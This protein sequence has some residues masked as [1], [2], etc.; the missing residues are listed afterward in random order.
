M[1]ALKITSIALLLTNASAFT[2]TGKP[3]FTPMRITSPLRMSTVEESYDKLCEVASTNVDQPV[4]L[5][6]STPQPTS[7]EQPQAPMNPIQPKKQP[8]KKKSNPA[9]QEGVFSPLVIAFKVIL[10][11]DTLKKVRAKAISLH[12]DVIANFVDTYSTPFGQATLARLFTI[13]DTNEDG[14][15]D[16]SEL[17]SGLHKLG[18]EWLKEKQISGIVKRSDLDKNGVIDYEEF[19]KAAPKTL[20]TNLTKLAKKNGGEMGLLV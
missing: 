20:R 11:E 12:S 17:Q 14:V 10:G 18:F 16:P 8:S 5:K 1:T 6:S 2:M 13:L 15:L 7:S 3:A 19:S 9:H 4:N